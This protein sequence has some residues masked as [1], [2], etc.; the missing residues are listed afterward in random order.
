M[1]RRMRRWAMEDSDQGPVYLGYRIGHIKGDSRLFRAVVYNK[2][3]VVLHTLRRLL[4][5]EAFFRG[6]RRYYFT[7]RFRK[8]GTRDLQRA[9]EAEAGVSLTRFFDRWI[10]GSSIPEVKV[11]T[12]TEGDGQGQ[13]IVVRFEQVGEVFDLPVTV[14]LDY[15]DRPPQEV[16]VKLAEQ[17]VETRIP[18]RGRLRKVDINRDEITIGEF[19]RQSP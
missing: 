16:L 9:F 17:I 15:L 10:I 8:A 12:H 2:G 14:T 3:A 13:E 7:W 4:G 19:V 18:L 6:L 5:D 1:I 11:T